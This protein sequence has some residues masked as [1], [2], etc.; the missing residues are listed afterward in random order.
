LKKNKNAPPLEVKRSKMSYH[1]LAAAHHWAKAGTYR[2][3]AFGAGSNAGDPIHIPDDS[4]DEDDAPI[5]KQ[6]QIDAARARRERADALQRDERVVPSDDARYRRRRFF[7]R[8][9]PNTDEKS[10]GGPDDALVAV[11]HVGGAMSRPDDLLNVCDYYRNTRLAESEIQFGRERIA[12][13][14]SVGRSPNFEGLSYSDL[15]HLFGLYDAHFFAGAFRRDFDKTGSNLEMRP[16]AALSRSAGRCVFDK[17][18]QKNKCVYTIEIA[19]KILRDAFG[20]DRPPNPVYPIGGLMCRNRLECMQLTLEHEMIHLLMFVWEEC[21]D[22]SVLGGHGKTFQRLAR[23]IFGHTETQHGLFSALPDEQQ[24][25]TSE[26]IARAKEKLSVGAGV[27]VGEHI[28]TV[29]KLGTVNFLAMR[30]DGLGPY[31][32]NYRTP[33]QIASSAD[34]AAAASAADAA[35]ART[36]EARSALR[37]GTRVAV[38]KRIFTVTRLRETTFLATDENGREVAV[39][40]TALTRGR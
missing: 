15:D 26:R 30:S 18:L 14:W 25:S 10:E 5:V 7:R 6:N 36:D 16:S 27:V 23:N 31:K 35:A 8:S 33:F 2:A 34:A 21:N 17:S 32:I 4:E 3:M 28:Y 13:E 12:T 24:G 11:K 29:T 37:P 9:H 20:P 19:T 39:R 1:E 38:G 40:Y 22:K